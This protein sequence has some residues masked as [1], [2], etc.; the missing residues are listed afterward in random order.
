MPRH[1]LKR[2]GF[3]LLQ[4]LGTLLLLAL[5]PGNLLKAAGLLC[6]WALTFR[7]VSW[8]EAA[9]FAA[10]SAL[11]VVMNWLSL[12]NGIFAFSD[13]D[14]LA[15]PIWEFGMW[16]FY[17]LNTQRA[18][19]GPVP[20]PAWQAWAYAAAFGVCFSVVRDPQLLLV[21]AGTVV[22]CALI[23][24]HAREDFMYA[25]YF[26]A[27]GALVEY[28]G[29]HTGLWQ[30]PRPP[31]GGVPFWFVALFAGVGLFCRRIGLPLLATLERQRLVRPAAA[32]QELP[33]R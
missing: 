30:Y 6:W 12:R 7:R 31:A 13:P 9:C 27:L 4:L 19:G 2:F 26:A 21:S 25:G 24:F 32:L 18:L 17:L 16:G 10:F 28:T 8:A 14:W 23:R 22:A 33:T 3:H 1:E 11:F 15:Q 20:R 5:L 29:V